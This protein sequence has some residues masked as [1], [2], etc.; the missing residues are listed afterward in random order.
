MA[1]QSDQTQHG[2]KICAAVTVQAAY[3][4]HCARMSYSSV[5]RAVSQIQSMARTRSAN[6][7]YGH[8]RSSCVTI[9]AT[10]RGHRA[11][12]AFANVQQCRAAT[13]IASPLRSRPSSAPA[14][15]AAATELRTAAIG[16]KRQCGSQARTAQEATTSAAIVVQSA[17]RRCAARKALQTIRAVVR[18]SLMAWSC[19]R[20]DSRAVW[21]CCDSYRP[22]FRACS[23][24]SSYTGSHRRH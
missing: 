24:R 21:H 22:R 12:K 20:E 23:Q 4:A 10:F 2:T 13:V 9:E 16:V 6:R 5:M 18:P 1:W 19:S 15:S 7:L 8:A 11:R 14:L 17:Q 3:R